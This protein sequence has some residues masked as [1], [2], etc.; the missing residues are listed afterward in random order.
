MFDTLNLPTLD[1]GFEWYT[2]GLYTDG[3]LL[4]SLPRDWLDRYD[5]SPTN[6]PYAD[7][8]TDGFSILAEYIA[9]TNPTNG[10]SYFQVSDVDS[11]PDPVIHFNSSTARLYTLSVCT[12]MRVDTWTNVTDAGPRPGAG[13][14]DSFTD[15]NEPAEGLFYYRLGVELE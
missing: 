4:V 8:D 6:D 12:D 10:A 13:G 7:P 2:N 3:S 14:P 11:Y 5:L 9:D 1:M 15:T